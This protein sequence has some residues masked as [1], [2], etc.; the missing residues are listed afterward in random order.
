MN[1]LQ[2]ESFFGS[3]SLLSAVQK[4]K[5]NANTKTA[6]QTILMSDAAIDEITYLIS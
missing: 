2:P 6:D 4:A 1:L 3:Q 5:C